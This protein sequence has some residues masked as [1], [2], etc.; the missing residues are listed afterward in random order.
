MGLSIVKSGTERNLTHYGERK[1][2]ELYITDR[3]GNVV[4]KRTVTAPHIGNSSVDEPLVSRA[5]GQVLKDEFGNVLYGAGPHYYENY[6]FDPL[7][8]AILPPD[9]VEIPYF[10]PDG[11]WNP[12]YIAAFKL[13]LSQDLIEPTVDALTPYKFTVPF[14]ATI[15]SEKT[16]VEAVANP[17]G[18]DC[19]GT[20]SQPMRASWDPNDIQGLPSRPY[21]YP[22]EELQFTIRFENVATATAEAE[23]VVVTMTVDPNLDWSTLE[24][25]GTSHPDKLQLR[26]DEEQRTLVWTFTDINLPPNQ[27]PP[28]GEGWIRFRVQPK[29]NLDSGTVLTAQAVI[30]FDMNPPSGPMWSPI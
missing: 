1:V 21:I 14:A 3:W 29:V 30:V 9:K 2:G 11:S 13:R 24:M 18:P 26:A 15:R 25:L 17:M 19:D 28:Q 10:L 8:K 12:T 23:T 16:I 6:Y 27:D 7:L 5:T 20:R 22:A 4:E